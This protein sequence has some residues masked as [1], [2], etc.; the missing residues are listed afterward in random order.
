MEYRFLAVIVSSIL[1]LV[2]AFALATPP[3]SS[4]GP[5]QE[6]LLVHAPVMALPK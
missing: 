3:I 2:T 5:P 6:T 1:V 4:H